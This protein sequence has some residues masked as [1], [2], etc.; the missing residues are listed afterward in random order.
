MNCHILDGD[1]LKANY[2]ENWTLGDSSGFLGNT[3][4]G[5]DNITGIL[6]IDF[7]SNPK[8][9]AKM[10]QTRDKINL[11]FYL[12][13][14]SN[15]WLKKNFEFIN[16]IYAGSNWMHL[17]Y[18]FIRPPN[19]YHVLCPGR[20]QIYW[21]AIDVTVTFEGKL[22][23]NKIVSQ[24]LKQYSKAIDDDMLW[25]DAWKMSINIRDLTPNNFNL[26]AEYYQKGFVI[27]EVQS[28]EGE[29]SLSGVFDDLKTWYEEFIKTGKDLWNDPEVTKLREDV[30]KRGE[31]IL[32]DLN[33]L[34]EQTFDPKNNKSNA[35]NASNALPANYPKTETQ[36]R[37]QS[38]KRMSE[39]IATERS[40]AKTES[41]M[42]NVTIKQIQADA[43]A[44]NLSKDQTNALIREYEG[45]LGSNKFKNYGQDYIQKHNG[46]D[47]AKVKMEKERHQKALEA[48]FVGQKL[49]KRREMLERNS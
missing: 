40:Q 45:Q 42:K 6:G 39:E 15:E 1:Y 32:K 37:A 33:V 38:W 49:T 29:A 16:A 25:P 2:S 26:Y 12:I 17:K 36:V 35:N 47:V 46:S 3:L 8:F 23:Q 44:M 48:A 28:L 11:E 14:S 4:A 43:A 18:C 31:Q 7:P 10:N 30:K 24:A 19:V 27:K 5:D 9:K 21:A 20:F 34:S 22:R 41:E 13:N